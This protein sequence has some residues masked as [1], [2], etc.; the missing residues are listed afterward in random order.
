MCG[1]LFFIFLLLSFFTHLCVD[2]VAPT[3]EAAA[4]GTPA[5]EADAAPEVN[6]EPAAD[7]ETPT[8]EVKNGILCLLSQWRTPAQSQISKQPL[9]VPSWISGRELA[10]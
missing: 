5:P 6:G 1:C 2:D 3:E 4:P 8:A 7:E 10:V 9:L